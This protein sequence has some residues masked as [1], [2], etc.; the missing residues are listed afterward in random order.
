[1]MG[2]WRWLVEV[3][4]RAWAARRDVPANLETRKVA[5]CCHTCRAAATLITVEVGRARSR[6]CGATRGSGG[7]RRGVEAYGGE[8]QSG[9]PVQRE[10]VNGEIEDARS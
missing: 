6:D 7:V 1:M 4:G 3:D 9:W 10:E 5:A 2:T 8:S